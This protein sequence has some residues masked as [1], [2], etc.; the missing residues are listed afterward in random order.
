MSDEIYLPLSP[1]TNLWD[2]DRIVGRALEVLRL[3]PDDPDTPRVYDSAQAACLLVDVEVD[4]E[5]PTAV[6]QL[7]EAAAVQ[8]TIELYRRK[9]APFGVVDAWSQ[10]AIA[11]RISGDPLAGILALVRPDKTRWGVA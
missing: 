2:V 6:S 9:D 3:G 11:F 8:C 1:A 5:L 4:H 7:M 10:D